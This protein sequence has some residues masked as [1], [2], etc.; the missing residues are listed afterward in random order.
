MANS[1]YFKNCLEAIRHTVYGRDNRKPI[2]DSISSIVPKFA[3]MNDK[4]GRALGSVTLIANETWYTYD[5]ENVNF[6]DI[7]GDA[8][9]QMAIAKKNNITAELIGGNDYFFV[10]GIDGD[11]VSAI[12][13]NDYLLNVIN[14]LIHVYPHYGDGFTLAFTRINGH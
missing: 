13:G 7:D 4:L 10:D 3:Y 9:N 11:S 1:V 12:A 2:A 5:Y 6:E 8:A 14:P